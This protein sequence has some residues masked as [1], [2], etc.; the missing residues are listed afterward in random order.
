MRVAARWS[1][2]MRAALMHHSGGMPGSFLQGVNLPFSY[3]V[4]L[5]S[6]R[7]A[8]SAAMRVLSA[9]TTLSDWMKASRKSSRASKRS[10]LVMRVALGDQ[11]VGALIVDHLV[12]GQNEVVVVDLDVALSDHPAAL[13]VV[14]QLVG[15]QVERLGLIDLGCWT[16]HAAGLL[17]EGRLLTGWA[18]TDVK[19]RILGEGGQRG[20]DQDAKR[21]RA[22]REG[23]PPSAH[24]TA[25]NPRT[26]ALSVQFPRPTH[27]SAVLL[28]QQ[29][30]QRNEQS[31]A[32]RHPHCCRRRHQ[33][34]NSDLARHLSQQEESDPP[35]HPHDD[36]SLDPT[37][38]E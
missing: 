29:H 12:G 31:E 36:H 6:R 30:R 10:A 11:L 16:E 25:A 3:S 2:M 4:V 1:W 18:V 35:D 22:K 19:A 26:A 24:V 38:P 15:L 21:E 20:E 37:R 13:G 14:E 28:V 7:V 17:G 23:T 27:H 34:S 33:T 5:P 8:R 9:V 32:N